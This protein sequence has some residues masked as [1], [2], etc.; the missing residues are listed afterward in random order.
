MLEEVKKVV[1]FSTYH[2]TMDALQAYYGSACVRV[3]GRVDSKHKDKLIHH[4]IDSDKCRVFIGQNTAAGI[5]INLVVSSDAV[6]MDFTLTP[7]NMEQPIK[8]LNRPGATKPTNI[9]YTISEG[10]VDEKIFYL[11]KDKLDDINSILDKGSKGIVDYDDL[12]D[13]LIKE[14]IR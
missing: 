10:S 13:R 4:F 3:D 7:D 11:L 14:L 2:D 12:E 5:G 9:Y 1:I 8:R 6:F